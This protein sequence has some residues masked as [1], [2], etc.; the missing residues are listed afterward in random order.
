MAPNEPARKNHEA[1]F[2]NH[3]STVAA[4]DPERI[5]SFHKFAFDE[6]L[7]ESAWTRTTG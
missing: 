6:V 5:E 1:L 4:T 7:R 2:P 3:A